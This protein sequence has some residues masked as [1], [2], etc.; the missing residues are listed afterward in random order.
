MPHKGIN[1]RLLWG[2]V[3]A[4][5]TGLRNPIAQRVKS[6]MTS[7]PSSINTRSASRN[8]QCRVGTPRQ[9]MR[10]Q[11][12]TSAVYLQKEGVADRP[13]PASATCDETFT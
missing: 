12:K 11:T 7:Q 1:I 8:K 4:A 13:E 2:G 5:G 3:F 9:S 10:Q 6:A